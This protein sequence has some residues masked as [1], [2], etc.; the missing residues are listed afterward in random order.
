MQR[1]IASLLIFSV[2]LGLTAP[3]AMAGE[4]YYQEGYEAGERAAL[5]DIR[6]LYKITDF[7]WGFMFGPLPVVYS[8]I[9]NVKVP[10]KVVKAM[11]GRN[12]RYR[13]GFKEGYKRTKKESKLLANFSGWIGWIGT[14]AIAIPHK[15]GE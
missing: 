4:D 11:D 10:D 14:W 15:G 6:L 8:L 2:G 12:P 5:Q 7:L 9:D 13:E 3:L 1:F